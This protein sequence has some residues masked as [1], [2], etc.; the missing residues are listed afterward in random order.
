M[1]G[2]L[3]GD[4]CWA[5]SPSRCF[6]CER[7]RASLLCDEKHVAN[8]PQRPLVTAGASPRSREW[9]HETQ[10]TMDGTCSGQPQLAHP[11]SAPTRRLAKR[12]PRS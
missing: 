9:L 4:C 11:G 1:T 10:L 12:H 2:S 7:A 3:K 6:S 5:L 8:V